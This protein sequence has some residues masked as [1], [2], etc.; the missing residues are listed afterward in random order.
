DA[1]EE[2]ELG[3]TDKSRAANNGATNAPAA[4]SCALSAE[5]SVTSGGSD[6][7]T[8]A[9]LRQEHPQPQLKLSSTQS[10]YVGM[11]AINPPENRHSPSRVNPSLETSG[12]RAQIPAWL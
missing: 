11:R 3:H 12:V 7:R 6:R 8:Y 9:L 4:G 5:P 2:R 1:A 10:S